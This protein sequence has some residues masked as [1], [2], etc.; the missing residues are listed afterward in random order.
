MVYCARR[1]H[2]LWDSLHGLLIPAVL[3]AS[4]CGTTSSESVTGPD[5]P[6]CSVTL[7]AA[8]DSIA[9][10]GGAGSIT[11]TTQ[12]ECAWQAVAEAIWITNLIPSQGQGNAEVR[13]Q[14]S[15][16]PN[17]SARESVIVVN[18]QRAIIRQ[19]PFTCQF[20]VGAS[21]TQFA[22]AGGTGTITIT[23]FDGCA[24][25]ASS[26]VSWIVIARSGTGSGSVSFTVA[27]NIGAVR[28]GRVTVGDASIAIVQTGLAG[29]SPACT[30]T[31]QPASMSVAAS[32]GPATVAVNAGCAW[33]ASSGVP[34]ITLTIP[35]SGSG[36]GTVGFNVAA[37]T[38]SAGRVGSLTVGS[39]ALTVTQA[40]APCPVSINPTGRSVTATGGNLNV[41]VSTAAGCP[42]GATSQAFFIT[43]TAGA[44]GSGNG[45]VTLSVAQNTGGARTGTAT[46]GG[47][48]FTVNQACPSLIS[49]TFR[50]VGAGVYTQQTVVVTTIGGCTWT[51][52]SHASWLTITSGAG[53]NGSGHVTYDVAA[54]SGAVRT[55]TLTI[56]DQTL[57]VTQAGP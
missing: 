57:T 24:W 53:G 31:L 33:T 28:T 50:E 48:T 49:P 22:A 52:T 4:A 7:I 14:I 2:C 27:P 21:N 18:N 10:S 35:A 16:N 11:V 41:A 47:Q 56:A 55:G 39:A 12:P 9:G 45:S 44:S 25:T 30:V 51:A 20:G 5:A 38:S 32:G 6:K 37:N 29:G 34:W 15:Q 42:W 13:F 1:G 46:I 26:D 3:I 43:I 23:S 54:N 8:E 19:A 17:A 40:G 36:N